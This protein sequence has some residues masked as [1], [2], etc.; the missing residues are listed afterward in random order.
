MREGLTMKHKAFVRSAAA[1]LLLSSCAMACGQVFLREVWYSG[2]GNRFR[3][4]SP[5]AGRGPFKDRWEAK[6]TGRLELNIDEDFSA[7]GEAY[8]YLELW[9]GHPGVANKRFRLNGG[10]EQTIPEVGA[11]GKNCTYSYPSIRLKLDELK[12]GQNVFQF[13]CDRGEAF[14][15]HY[16]IRAACV[17]MHLKEGHPAVKEAGLAGFYPDIAIKP[18]RD[19]EG[20]SLA[21]PVPKGMEERISSVEYWGQYTGYD[22]NGDGIAEGPHGFTK[23][24]RPVGNIGVAD[25]PPYAVTWD[26]SM[27]PDQD[28]WAVAVDAKVRFKGLDLVHDGGMHI[29]IPPKRTARV[30]LHYSK[31]VPRPFWSR[32]AQ[33]RTCTIHLDADPADVER[34]ELHV[35]IWDGGKGST[36][37]PFTLNGHA[38]PVAGAGRHDVLYRVVPVEAK[39][40]KKGPNEIRLL[41]DT[42]HHGIEVLLPG[43]A[44]IVRTKGKP[45]P[46][47]EGTP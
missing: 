9:G 1:A 3:V 40:L 24:G 13:T 6:Q 39:I 17:R 15:G 4:N 18:L 46:R 41:S 34:A 21:L 22:E 16:L 30:T 43:P 38:L 37:E 25:K 20:F 5:D 23:D 33:A 44:L 45:A 42:E 35:V 7:L 28:T 11:A 27:L 14:W 32:A 19:G 12:R 10:G 36:K 47:V 2:K 29:L 8:L 26:L 31:D